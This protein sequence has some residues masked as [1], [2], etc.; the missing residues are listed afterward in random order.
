[1]NG[2]IYL[3][4]FPGMYDLTDPGFSQPPLHKLQWKM[5]NPQPE[6]WRGAHEDQMV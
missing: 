1:M 4:R 3:Q 5:R 6:S 2:E